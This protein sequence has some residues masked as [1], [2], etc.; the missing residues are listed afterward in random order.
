MR[1]IYALS[2][3]LPLPL[4]IHAASPAGETR[5]ADVKR[6]SEAPGL[7][8]SADG[9]YQARTSVRMTDTAQSADGSYRFKS[10]LATCDPSVVVLFSDGFE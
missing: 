4:A 6:S 5:L 7:A 10:T 1:R 8:T 2:L 3:L 9:V